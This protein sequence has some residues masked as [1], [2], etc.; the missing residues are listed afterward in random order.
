MIT[1]M[2]AGLVEMK[3]AWK[4]YNALNVKILDH[5]FLCKVCKKGVR[6][7]QYIS[8]TEV[9]NSLSFVERRNNNAQKN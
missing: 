3:D 1:G 7:T 4:I 9:R 6:C 2:M 8:L 5:I